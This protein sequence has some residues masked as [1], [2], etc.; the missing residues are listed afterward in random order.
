MVFVLL[1]AQLKVVFVLLL[2]QLKVV[3]VLLL[4]QLKVVFV[5]LLAQLKVVFVLFGSKNV[6]KPRGKIMYKAIIAV[7]DLRLKSTIVLQ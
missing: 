4:A 3:F 1:L 2:A 7:A 5:L 6:L